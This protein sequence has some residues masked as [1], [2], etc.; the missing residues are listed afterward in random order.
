MSDE[1]LITLTVE[2]RLNNAQAEIVKYRR[3]TDD[4]ARDMS[5]VYAM[6]E[7]FITRCNERGDTYNIHDAVRWAYD[8]TGISPAYIKEFLERTGLTDPSYCMAEYNVHM[9]IP[10]MI[11]INVSALD[12]DDA[13]EVAL[14]ELDTNGIDSYNMDY[15]T[16]DIDYDVEEC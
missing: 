8:D 1:N 6:C 3:M 14:G 9:T 11:T 12:E 2:E 7:H 5:I 13:Y 15:N 4:A 10:V 16:Y